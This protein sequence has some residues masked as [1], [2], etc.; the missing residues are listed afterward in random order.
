VKGKWQPLIEV[1]PS[2]KK[3]DDITTSITKAKK[4]GQSFDDWVK[5]RGYINGKQ[6]AKQAKELGSDQGG[7]SDFTLNKIKNNDYILQEISIKDLRKADPDLDD[8]LKTSE[9]REYEGKPFGMNP[10]VDSNGEVLDGYNRI[11]QSIENG[12]NT[13]TVLKGKTRSQMRTEWDKITDNKIQSS[14]K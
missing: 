4:S 2:L 3:V 11:A 1:K 14:K 10:I 5:Y 12:E 8:Y 7:L 13:I 9:I 6:I